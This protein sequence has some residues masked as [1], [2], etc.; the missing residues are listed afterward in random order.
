MTRSV[1]LDAS[2]ARHRMTYAWEIVCE[3]VKSGKPVRVRIDEHAPS[4]SVD[5]NAKFHSICGELAKK[6]EWAGRKRDTEGWKRLLV[7]TWARVEG[8]PQGDIV[9]S[10]DGKSVVNLG[11]QTR[12]MKVKDMCDLIEFAHS[13]CV[14]NDVELS[15]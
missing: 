6:C 7:D 8:M 15:Q 10:L 5:Q 11:I 9:P 1:F 4:R 14:D 2:T 3:L 13:W 12:S